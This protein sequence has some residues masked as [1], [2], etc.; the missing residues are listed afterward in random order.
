MKKIFLCAA[1]TFALFPI[2]SCNDN[3]EKQPGTHTHDDGS[4]HEDH[5]TDSAKPQQEEFRVTDSTTV[6]ADTSKKP[7]THDGGKPHTH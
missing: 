4:V 2:F 3:A 5:A 6:P 7:H 1:L